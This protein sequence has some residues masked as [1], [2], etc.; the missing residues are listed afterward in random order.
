[1]VGTNCVRF[2]PSAERQACR[3]GVVGAL[4]WSGLAGI[5]LRITIVVLA[6]GSSGRQA[7][8]GMHV[9][10]E[11]A[12][13]ALHGMGLS[14]GHVRMQLMTPTV[15]CGCCC[16]CWAG[17]SREWP[18]RR[19]KQRLRRAILS[20][21]QIRAGGGCGA[22][23][24]SAGTLPAGTLYTAVDIDA[25]RSASALYEVSCEGRLTCRPPMALRL[26]EPQH[27]PGGSK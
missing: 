15:P 6:W 18:R 21:L 16:S 20:V 26:L 7:A 23:H 25:I 8:S 22:C 10:I 11:A 9:S 19:T 17:V 24:P 3:R 14:W 2:V 12:L 1:M 5:C 13:E 27:A 4:V